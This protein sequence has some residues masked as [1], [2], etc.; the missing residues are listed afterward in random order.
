MILITIKDILY[1]CFHDVLLMGIGLGCCIF[2]YVKLGQLFY[3][4]LNMHIRPVHYQKKFKSLKKY[5]GRKALNDYL[6]WD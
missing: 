5:S 1:Y 6:Y 4:I 3:M 2:L